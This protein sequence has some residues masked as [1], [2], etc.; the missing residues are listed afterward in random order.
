VTG[1]PAVPP[2]SAAG[3]AAAGLGGWPPL[4][5]PTIL[6]RREEIDPFSELGKYRQTVIHGRNWLWWLIA[7]GV[8]F[9]LVPPLA[10]VLSAIVLFIAY[11]LSLQFHTLR[12]CRFCGGTGRRYG[13]VLAWSRNHRMCSSCGGQGRHRRWGAM[14]IYRDKPTL[15]E[16]R[17]V[18][19]SNR[20][21]RP[22]T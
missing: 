15:A 6:I 20:R 17:Q 12:M 1:V 9:V 16:R 11:L 18:A 3:T 19:A 14:V 7:A 13:S 22:L 2:A 4:E 21:A 5:L 8:Y 10:K